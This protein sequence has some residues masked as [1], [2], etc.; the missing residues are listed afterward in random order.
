MRLKDF[1]LEFP[2][3]KTSAALY[4]YI[5]RLVEALEIILSEIGEE[6]LSQELKEKIST[7]GKK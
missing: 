3:E 1:G 5:Y 7:G 6:N 4:D 2:R